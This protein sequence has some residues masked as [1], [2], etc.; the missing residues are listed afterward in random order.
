MATGGDTVATKR[1]PTLYSQHVLILLTLHHV[2]CATVFE[3]L[4]S[5]V[6]RFIFVTWRIVLRLSQLD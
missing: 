2:A 1:L 3:V 5:V 4:Q 6:P